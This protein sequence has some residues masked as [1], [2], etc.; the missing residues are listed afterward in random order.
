MPCERPLAASSVFVL[1]IKKCVLFAIEQAEPW[2]E[3]TLLRQRWWGRER[4]STAS[5]SGLELWAASKGR[6]A[7]W[8]SERKTNSGDRWQQDSHCPAAR[9]VRQAGHT[10]S[11][12]LS[13]SGR[14]GGS[15]P[16]WGVPGDLCRLT[17]WQGQVLAPK[18][19]SLPVT[20]LYPKQ[21][22]PPAWV[23]RA[24]VQRALPLQPPWS[25]RPEAGLGSSP[26]CR[27]G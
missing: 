20:T 22:L 25:G 16:C 27:A 21:T 13:H 15:R 18:Q 14:R 3:R 1:K 11:R 17:K 5:E 6:K 4:N 12:L 8:R 7:R 9:T 19:C 10:V 26:G 2:G 23:L 24:A